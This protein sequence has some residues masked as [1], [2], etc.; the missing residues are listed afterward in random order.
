MSETDNL[1]Q[2]LLDDEKTRWSTLPVKELLTLENNSLHK[3]KS[4]KTE[5]EYELI[6]EKPGDF[7]QV[8]NHS[9]I[10]CATRKLLPIGIIYRRYY[11]GFSID[12]TGTIIPLPDEA[13]GRYD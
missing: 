8:K 13:I 12:P 2:R 5:I 6:H 10:L 4:G 9:F 3:L 7:L 1:W 11:S